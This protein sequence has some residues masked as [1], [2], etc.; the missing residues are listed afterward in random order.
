MGRALITLTTDFG[1]RDSYV[2]AMKGVILGI[3]PDALIVDVSHQVARHNVAEAAYTL[4]SAS[5]Y[6]PTDAIHVAVVDPGVGSDRRPVLAETPMGTYICPDN[7]TLTHV[8]AEL[9]ATI[10]ASGEE[11]G[12]T[13]QARL[14]EGCAAYELDAPR[15]WLPRVTRTFHGRDVFAPVAARLA[16]GV[17]ASELGSPVGSLACLPLAP[18]SDG[19]T[20]ATGSVAHIDHYGNLVTNIPSEA[21]PPGCVVR[22]AGRSI[23]GLSDSYQEAVG[24]LLAIIGSQHTLEIAVGEGNAA[25]YLAA[26]VG[27]PVTVVKTGTPG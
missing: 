2:A 5:R 16:S 13:V 3:C 26:A 24:G 22:V 25:E 21:A 12:S 14:P 11:S 17:P 1:E 4:L 6:Y 9:G 10:P 15:H 7:G 23:E 19:E 27:T 8:L 20:E 18:F